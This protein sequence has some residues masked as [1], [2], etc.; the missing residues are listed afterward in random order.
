[1]DV[2]VVDDLLLRFVP[3]VVL[4]DSLAVWFLSCDFAKVIVSVEHGISWPPIVSW[5]GRRVGLGAM[6]KT[7]VNKLVC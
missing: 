6:I 2:L 5:L 1:M 4:T 7:N 3:H